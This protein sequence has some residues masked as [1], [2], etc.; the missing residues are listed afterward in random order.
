MKVNILIRIWYWSHNSSCAHL[1]QWTKHWKKQ[2]E[3]S[4][5]LCSFFAERLA[6]AQKGRWTASQLAGRVSMKA[7]EMKP[8]YLIYDSSYCAGYSASDLSYYLDYY[9]FDSV[10]FVLLF[11]VGFV[12]VVLVFFVVFWVLF[13]LFGLFFFVVC[14]W[15]CVC[16]VGFSFIISF[17]TFVFQHL[18]IIF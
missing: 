11:V 10:V 5:A 18:Y 17:P 2:P 15:F 4:R 14:C 9:L 12:F 13:W 6:G 16:C 1:A 7:N 8:E 3:E